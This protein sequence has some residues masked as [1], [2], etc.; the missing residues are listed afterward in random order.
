MPTVPGW[1]VLAEFPADLGI[2][3][4]QLHHADL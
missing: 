3:R 2:G 4:G 1:S